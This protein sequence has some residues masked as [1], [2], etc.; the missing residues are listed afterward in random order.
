MLA[1]AETC[2]GD[3]GAAG[4]SER[5]G[6]EVDRLAHEE[7]MRTKFRLPPE[8]KDALHAEARAYG[9]SVKRVSADLGN[10]GS[11]GTATRR[12]PSQVLPRLANRERLKGPRA[13][14]PANPPGEAAKARGPFSYLGTRFPH[15]WFSVCVSLL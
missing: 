2:A 3:K 13:L 6:A 4:R 10:T 7:A 11:R 8:E 1:P 14:S 15:D 12:A 9:I 5:H